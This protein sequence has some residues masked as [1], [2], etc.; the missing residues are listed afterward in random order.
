MDIREARENLVTTLRILRKHGFK[1]INTLDLEKHPIEGQSVWYFKAIKELLGLEEKLNEKEYLILANNF[2]GKGIPM[3]A[4]ALDLEKFFNVEKCI[5][6]RKII[7]VA[8]TVFLEIES[9]TFETKNI[10]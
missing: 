6:I 2:F 1:T 9:M 8:Y 7:P 4:S 10:H 3:G 5:F